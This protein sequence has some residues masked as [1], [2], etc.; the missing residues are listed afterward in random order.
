MTVFKVI[1]LPISGAG[2]GLIDLRSDGVE[3]RVAISNGDIPTGVIFF[4]NV[5]AFRFRDEMHS[6][7][8]A[9]GSYDTVV[10]IVDS[11]WLKKLVEI[12]PVQIMGSVK[13]SRHFAV[14]LSSNGY[15]EVIAKSVEL[16]PRR[17]S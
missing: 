2:C 12:E 1:D 17:E 6:L 4:D 3:L 16:E 15:L 10:E 5:T 8:Y 13:G 11:K 9:D 14:L 7:G